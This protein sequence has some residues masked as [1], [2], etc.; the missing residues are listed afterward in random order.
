M[1]IC[2][3]ALRSLYKTTIFFY[4]IWKDANDKQT[5][6]ELMI[7]FTRQKNYKHTV[8]WFSKMDCDVDSWRGQVVQ[9]IIHIGEL[10]LAFI[11]PPY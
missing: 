7:A 5:L 11:N 2:V 8:L 9:L 10:A 6:S 4:Q 1:V 3:K